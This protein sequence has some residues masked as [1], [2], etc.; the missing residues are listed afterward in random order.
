MTT[1]VTIGLP[2]RVP[3]ATFAMLEEGSG[4]HQSNSVSIDIDRSN[5]TDHSIMYQ[6]QE[7]ENNTYAKD[8]GDDYLDIT[9]FTDNAEED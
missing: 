6:G 8:F 4:L 5:Y 7:A 1:A 9:G 3:A 2:T